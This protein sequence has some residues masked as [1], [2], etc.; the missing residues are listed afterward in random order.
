FEAIFGNLGE[1]KPSEEILN[2]RPQN[3]FSRA[4][5]RKPIFANFPR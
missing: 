4:G 3:C 2:A 5:I 1:L